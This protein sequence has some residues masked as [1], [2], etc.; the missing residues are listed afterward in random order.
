MLL[1]SASCLAIALAA[2][3]GTL[4]VTPC[5]GRFGEYFAIEDDYGLIEVALTADEAAQRVADVVKKTTRRG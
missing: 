3:S 4:K 1:V 2:K 5:Q